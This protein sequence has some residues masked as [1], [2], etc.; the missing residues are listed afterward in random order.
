MCLPSGD[1]ED[2][3]K[4]QD[5]GNAQ[6]PGTCDSTRMCC[7]PRLTKIEIVSVTFTSDHGLLKDHTGSWSDGGSVYAEPEWTS[8]A[9]NPLSHTMDR[10]VKLVVK[11]RAEPAGESETGKL[12][13][14][15]PDGLVFEKDNVSFGGDNI[16]VNLESDR[17]LAKKV[18]E[19]DFKIRWSV[20]GTT[21]DVTPG[22]TRNTMYVTMGTPATRPAQ[23]GVTLKRMKQA[24]KSTTGAN[25]VDPHKIIEHV[26]SKWGSFNLSVVHEN[27][28][29]LGDE[30]RRP[31]GTLVGADCQTIVRYTDNV[32]QMIGCPGTAD[33]IVVW[34]KVPTPTTG[35]EN[36]AYVPNMADPKQWYND[37]RPHDPA[38]ARWRATLIDGDDGQNKYEACL[39]FSYGGTTAYYAG[40]VGKKANANEVITV[41]KSMSWRDEDTAEIKDVI[42]TY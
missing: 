5:A 2:R 28:W 33:F 37:H 15:G 34:A 42:H 36:P 40:G 1:S 31:D 7:I 21:V 32:T 24:V 6:Q 4:S 14:E 35:E 8:A 22:E 23:P 13:G 10:K 11:L 17:P 30:T 39:R 20:S 18:Q 27:A 12:R 29:E 3:N 41:F 9:Q 25:S 38:K 19:L 16:V 26:M